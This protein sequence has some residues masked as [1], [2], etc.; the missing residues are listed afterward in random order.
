MPHTSNHSI[1]APLNDNWLIT[2]EVPIASAVWHPCG[3]KRNLNTEL[4]LSRGSSTGTSLPDDGF[5][6]RQH[7]D[8]VPP[9]LGR[10]P[11]TA[12]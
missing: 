2:D 10:L 9:G 8:Q 11:V 1:R 4:R 12:E 6:R 7:H 3:E 5:H